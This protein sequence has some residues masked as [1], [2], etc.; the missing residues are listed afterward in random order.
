MCI[1]LCFLVVWLLNPLGIFHQNW[2]GIFSSSCGFHTGEK[3][4]DIWISHSMCIICF[5]TLRTFKILLYPWNFM[6]IC[7]NVAIF[8][9]LCLVLWPFSF[10]G[11]VSLRYVLIWFLWLFL[12]CLFSLSF[13][14][15]VY[16]S[17][18]RPP[19]C[20]L[21]FVCFQFSISLPF[22]KMCS[23]RFS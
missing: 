19:D 1:I 20:S 15:E 16:S 8:H 13:F 2:K 10:F 9:P 11:N 17:C 6:T 7:L 14:L 4:S 22:H 23:V 5:F 12:P 18:S 21:V 3:S